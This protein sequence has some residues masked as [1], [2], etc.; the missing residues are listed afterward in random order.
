LQKRKLA[1]EQKTVEP[2][3]VASQAPPDVA[4]YLST[5]QA[6]AFSKLSILELEELRIPGQ[7]FTSFSCL[8]EANLYPSR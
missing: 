3:S 4:V 8:V 2:P 5:Q 6:K 7:W 1:A